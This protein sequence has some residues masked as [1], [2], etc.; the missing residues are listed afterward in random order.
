VGEGVAVGVSVGAVS[1]TAV[2]AAVGA[3]LGAGVGAAAGPPIE[4]VTA[5]AVE[6]PAAVKEGAAC[7]FPAV[8]CNRRACELFLFIASCGMRQVR[9]VGPGPLASARVIRQRTAAR[10]TVCAMMRE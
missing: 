1:G 9:V 2:G 8:P 3:A 4:E 7:P 5:P 10:A 6:K